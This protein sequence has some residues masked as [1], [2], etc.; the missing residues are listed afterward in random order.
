MA[1]TNYDHAVI[2]FK[3]HEH[4]RG[5]PEY[6]FQSAKTDTRNFPVQE[7]GYWKKQP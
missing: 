1:R 3:A 7:E 6:E 4:N 2:S 5:G